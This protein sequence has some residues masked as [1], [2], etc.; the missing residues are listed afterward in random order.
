MHSLLSKINL[1]EDDQK[2]LLISTLSSV[3]SDPKTFAYMVI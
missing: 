2:N 1:I 3:A